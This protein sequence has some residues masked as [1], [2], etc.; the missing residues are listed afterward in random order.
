MVSLFRNGA[1]NDGDD[2]GD[3][4]NGFTEY[5]GRGIAGGTKNPFTRWASSEFGASA[6]R[7]SGFLRDI[8]GSGWDR[9][10]AVGKAALADARKA[11]VTV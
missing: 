8:T 6:E 11:T 1:G 10:E 3:V 5:F 4:L 2:R 9:L 7:K